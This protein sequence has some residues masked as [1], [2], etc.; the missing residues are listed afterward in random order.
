MILLKSE[1]PRKTKEDREMQKK[2]YWFSDLLYESL[3]EARLTVYRQLDI[4][5]QSAL[6]RAWP[7]EDLWYEAWVLNFKCYFALW[8]PGSPRK[9]SWYFSIYCYTIVILEC[10]SMPSAIAI[11]V[12]KVMSDTCPS[13]G[14]LRKTIWQWCRETVNIPLIHFATNTSKI[15]HNIGKGR[16]VRILVGATAPCCFALVLPCIC[17]ASISRLSKKNGLLLRPHNWGGWMDDALFRA[18]DSMAN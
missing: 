3:A 5:D 16:M 6:A 17:T 12:R 1:R 11:A 9:L 2:N 14:T 13:L 10:L 15:P 18:T 4:P 7:H 8:L